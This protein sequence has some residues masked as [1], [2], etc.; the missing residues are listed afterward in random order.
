MSITDIITVIIGLLIIA[1]IFTMNLL[2]FIY[3]D[4]APISAKKSEKKLKQ[5]Y[6]KHKIRLTLS[7]QN[8]MLK[9]INTGDSATIVCIDKAALCSYIF[10]NQYFKKEHI[11]TLWLFFDM[12]FD[13]TTDYKKLLSIYSNNYLYDTYTH[14]ILGPYALIPENTMPETLF[15]RSSIFPYISYQKN[16]FNIKYVDDYLICTEQNTE[17]NIT[18]K[19]RQYKILAEKYVLAELMYNFMDTYSDFEDS[20]NAISQRSDCQ[21]KDCKIAIGKNNNNKE[22][23]IDINKATEYELRNLPGI[24]I[25]LAK[26]IIDYRTKNNG[27]KNKNEFFELIKLKQHFVEQ[28]KNKITIKRYSKIV[29]AFHNAERV[30]DI[31]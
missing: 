22:I 1:F 28:L 30:V 4:D 9:L 10:N 20:F 6:K 8:I 5:Y 15:K 3:K 21:I 23:K 25:A 19:R 18:V 26:R 13:Q 27:F 2:G 17:G 14:Q 11:Y 16:N 24:N 29:T 31:L 7:N 12:Q